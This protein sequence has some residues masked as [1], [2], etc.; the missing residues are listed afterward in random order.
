MNTPSFSEAS[1]YPRYQLSLGAHRDLLPKALLQKASNYRHT[2]ETFL[3]PLSSIRESSAWGRV[4]FFDITISA[5]GT[6]FH[7]SASQEW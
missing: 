7:N 2:A 6:F 1:P 4:V 5:A 3:S